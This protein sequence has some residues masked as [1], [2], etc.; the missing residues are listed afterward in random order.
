MSETVPVKCAEV[1]L[2]GNAQWLIEK[3]TNFIIS[4]KDSFLDKSLVSKRQIKKKNLL[5][6]YSLYP[7]SS[8]VGFKDFQMG[9]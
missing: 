5:L 6:V 7:L 2:W 9:F 3:T 8:E 4:E 1:W